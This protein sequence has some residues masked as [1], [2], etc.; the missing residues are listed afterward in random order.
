MSHR[1]LILDT[2]YF[3][4]RTFHIMP[5]TEYLIP[6][7]AHPI[8]H[9]AD[10]PP[11]T[12]DRIYDIPFLSQQTAYF[13]PHT[14]YRAAHTHTANLILDT[15]HFV[16]R[17]S[18]M[19]SRSFLSAFSY[20][21]SPFGF[22]SLAPPRLGVGCRKL[23]AHSYFVGLAKSCSLRLAGVSA[24]GSHCSGILPARS[25]TSLHDGLML[26]PPPC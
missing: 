16:P 19:C 24:A 14:T 7:I 23:R 2:Q 13:I 11:H 10:R 18:C 1:I 4:L 20:H 6:Q 22:V 21:M 25:A 5:Q 17:S 15:S 9:T 12:S 3:I 26:R 8:L